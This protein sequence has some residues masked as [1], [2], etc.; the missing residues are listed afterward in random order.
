MCFK[1]SGVHGT[2]TAKCHKAYR[3][4]KAYKAYS[5]IA[6]TL[7]IAQCALP[8]DSPRSYVLSKFQSA[9]HTGCHRPF[10]VFP[11]FAVFMVSLLP[12]CA[13]RKVLCQPEGM[14]FAFFGRY[15]LGARGET[16]LFPRVPP[17][18]PVCGMEACGT[19]C[20]FFTVRG[21]RPIASGGG[22]A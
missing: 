2:H 8:A 7:C 15:A 6:R 11:V 18:R 10:T 12:P 19:Q 16:L 1:N 20:G 22:A 5:G 13:L 14:R 17:F 4:Y 9:W 3:A 21:A